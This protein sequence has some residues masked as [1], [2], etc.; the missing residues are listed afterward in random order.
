MV[1]D[2][3]AEFDEGHENPPIKQAL[4]VN[5]ARAKCVLEFE[6]SRQE[7]SEC[8]KKCIDLSCPRR[9][10]HRMRRDGKTAG[11]FAED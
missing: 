1:Q 8:L 9:D 3:R 7:E 10:S 5:F 11:I 2:S 6:N 4:R